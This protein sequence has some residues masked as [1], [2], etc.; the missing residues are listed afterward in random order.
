MFDHHASPGH[1]GGS[2]DLIA[3]ALEVAGISGA[4]CYEVTDRNGHAGAIEGIE[5]NLRFFRENRK[6]PRIKG[7]F[8]IHASFTLRDETLA[9]VA[10]RRP[11]EAGC[12]IHV[13]EHPV[14]LEA[15]LEAFGIGPVERLAQAGLLDDRALLAHGI[16]LEE[17]DY[18][19]VADARAVILHNPESNANN[20]VGRL[21]VP[22]VSSLGCRIGLGTDGMSSAMLRALRFAYLALRGE[23]R[24]P[25]AGFQALPSLLA[26]NAS[27]ARTYFDEPLLGELVP[28]APADIIAIDCPPPTPL[29]TENLFGHLVYGVSEAPVRHT[30]AWGEPVLE[31]FR[32]KTLDVEALSEEARATAPALWDR[33]SKLDWNT[34]YLGPEGP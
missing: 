31:D 29:T 32:H 1:I 22:G 24:N 28:G 16:H 33:F 20:G 26:E 2:L 14:D 6:N 30:V 3:G 25:E 19:K 15:S 21:D 8:G 7:V 17:A 5:E 12:H 11:P 34:P 27:V 10:D 4:L 13:A 9:L 18:R 23:T